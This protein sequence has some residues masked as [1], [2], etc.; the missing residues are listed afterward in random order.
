MKVT[1]E[2]IACSPPP[3]FHCFGLVLGLLA[4]IT[5]GASIV[6]PSETF[7]AK[8]ALQAVIDEKCTLLHGVPTMFSAYMAEKSILKTN[9]RLY[10]RGGIAAGAPVPRHLMLQVFATFG[11][12]ELTNVYGSY[13]AIP[14]AYKRRS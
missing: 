3:L 6:L 8:T 4:V 7:N 11:M 12:Q 1:K 9:P 13:P 2:D 14:T 10:L 5:H